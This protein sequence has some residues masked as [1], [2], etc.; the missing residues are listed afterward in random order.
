MTEHL[1]F[2]ETLEDQRIMR[3]LALVV[4][5]FMAFTVSM[6]VGVGIALG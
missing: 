1:N 4:A 6:A 5:C 3:R 2:E